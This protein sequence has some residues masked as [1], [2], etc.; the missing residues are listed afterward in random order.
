[1]QAVPDCHLLAR[2][3]VRRAVHPR[4]SPLQGRRACPFAEFGRTNPFR[5]E[6]LRERPAFANFRA[7]DPG[8]RP[9]IAARS[10][11]SGGASRRPVGASRRAAKSEIIRLSPMGSFCHFAP[12]GRTRPGHS[13]LV[14]SKKIWKK[15]QAIYKAESNGNTG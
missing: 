3:G 8:E 7:E 13:R 1:R 2:W 9:R 5:C 10:L 11:S 4:S 15:I 6:P 14:A 12:H